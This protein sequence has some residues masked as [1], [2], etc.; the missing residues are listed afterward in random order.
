MKWKTLAVLLLAVAAPA[1]CS[2]Q[3]IKAGTWTGSVTP[4]DGGLTVV[5]YDVT[6]IGD[7]LGVV[8]HA[9]EHGDFTVRNGHYAEGK[10]T[11]AFEPGITVRCTLARGEDGNF[12]G[13][14]LAEDGSVAQMTMVPPKE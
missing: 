10:I 6:V 4:P 2:A 1:L 14:C 7:S 12:A 11:F 9:G 5:T 3:T 8:I 13:E